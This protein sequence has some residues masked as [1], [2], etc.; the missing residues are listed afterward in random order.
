MMKRFSDRAEAGRTLAARL[1]PL[2]PTRTVIAALPRGGVPVAAEICAATGAPLDL[3]LVRKIGAPGQPELAV[4]AVTDGAATHYAVIREV[5][6]AFGLSDAEVRARGAR[7][8]AEIERRRALWFGT[9]PRVALKGKTVVVVDDGV[10]T[11]A[12]VRAALQAVHAAGAAR[13]VLALPVA[14]EGTLAA[15]S[16]LA[17]ETVCLAV[18]RPFHAVGAHYAAFPQVADAEVAAILARFPPAGE[19]Q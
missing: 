6:E 15:L 11:G 18:P 5:A 17:D 3:V 8:L 12:T 9:R 14:P 19:K 16:A 7:E 13:V 10:A 2:D 1:G 4:G